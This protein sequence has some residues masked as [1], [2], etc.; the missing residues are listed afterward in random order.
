[1]SKAFALLGTMTKKQIKML[2]LLREELKAEGE[3]SVF[4]RSAF[5]TVVL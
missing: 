2:V 5:E 3:A 4:I 1:M